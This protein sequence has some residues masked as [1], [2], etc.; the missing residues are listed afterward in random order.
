MRLALVA[1]AVLLL[2]GSSCSRNAKT[3]LAVV[4][5]EKTYAA[6][7]EQIDA[8]VESVDNS[9]RTG[10]LVVDKWYNPDSI[11]AHLFDMYNNNGLEGAVFIGDIPVPMLRDAQHFTT[12]FK[13]NQSMNMQRSSVPSDRFY[14]DFDLKFNF[15]KQDEQKKQFFYYSL[16]PESAQEIGCDIYSSRIKAPEGENKYEDKNEIGIGCMRC[17]VG[18]RRQQLFTQCKDNLGCGC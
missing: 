8:Y 9:Y 7:P 1:G 4:V 2:L 18:Y 14:D 15:I 3:T 12:A 11:K 13:M 16:L 17:V 5:D 10:V 6:I